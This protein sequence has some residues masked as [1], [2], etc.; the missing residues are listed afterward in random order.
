[1]MVSSAVSPCS[2]T[3]FGELTED[4]P[5]GNKLSNA[6]QRTDLIKTVAAEVRL[7]LL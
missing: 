5:D 4:C 2:A 7:L 3:C 6:Q 1:M